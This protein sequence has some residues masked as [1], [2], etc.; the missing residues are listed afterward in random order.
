MSDVTNNGAQNR[1]ELTHDGETAMAEYTRDGDTLTFT[2]TVVPRAIDGQG[3]GTRLVEGALDDVAA[4]GLKVVPQC[5][6]V[7]HVIEE[8]PKYQ[9]LVN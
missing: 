5:P 7:A 1:Y 8:T 2:H 3:V 4:R 9:S 6:F